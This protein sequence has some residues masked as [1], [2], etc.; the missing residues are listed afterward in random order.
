MEE[1]GHHKYT[2]RKEEEKHA[3]APCTH[4]IPGALYG[5]KVCLKCQQEK[6]A[7]EQMEKKK[8]E[9]EQVRRKEE[10]ER[11]YKEWVAKIRLPEYLKK[12]HPGRL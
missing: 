7:R 9:E 1:G 11:A 2:D 12:M 6:I 8:A 5:Y 10:K 4:G 3:N